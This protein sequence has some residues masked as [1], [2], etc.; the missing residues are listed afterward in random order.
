M[1]FCQSSNINTQREWEVANG[2]SKMDDDTTDDEQKH[3][4]QAF[5]GKIT[6][7]LSFC[8]HLNKIDLIFVVYL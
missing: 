4:I 5:A 6:E 3:F 7:F 8:V 1:F 2:S